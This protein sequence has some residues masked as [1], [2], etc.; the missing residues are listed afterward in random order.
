MIPRTLVPVKLNPASKEDGA[1]TKP[2]RLTTML[3]DR[4][5]VPSGTSDA[6]PLDGKSSIPA[7][8]PLQVLVGH[9][10]IP[11]GMEVKPLRDY[12]PPS[13][14]DA[15]LAIL[16]SRVVV[17]AYVEPVQPSKPGESRKFEKAPELTAELREVVEPDIYLTGEA[18]LLVEPEKK[19]DP[20]WDLVTRIVSVAVHFLLIIFLIS[21][22][23]IFPYH[24]PT[25]EE[26]VDASKLLGKV[27][28]P[29]GSIPKTPPPPVPTVHITPKV[30]NKIA[31]PRPEEHAPVLPPV[32]TPKPRE[33][34]D[35]PEAP[36]AHTPTTPTPPQQVAQ[37]QRPPDEPPVQQLFHQPTK[38]LKLG[39][40]SAD[41]SQVIQQGIQQGEQHAPGGSV[42]S[43]GGFPAGAGA[44]AGGPGMSSG[45]Q[46]LTPTEGV[47]F[48]SYLQRLLAV[49][50]RNWYAIMPE[51][52]LM[53][54][55]GVV[56]TTFQINRDGSVP[57]PDPVLERASGREPLDSAAMSAIRASSPFEPLPSQFKG[58]YIR[59]RIIFIYNIPPD[60]INLQ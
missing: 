20:K 44:N 46:I 49:L 11:R 60:Q 45:V 7:H 30:L 4:T 22:P 58:P 17:P 21:I 31:P 32:P 42:Y 54:D 9:T 1:P 3:D 48:N 16:D 29:P 41:P 33:N 38:P 8:F 56:F 5:V 59:L 6:P 52:A 28:I 40:P 35:L 51:S 25:Q 39:L 18:N 10:L 2:R 13:E 53:G 26:I 47:D 57:Y 24:P 23:K 50:K 27:Y 36:K 19:R 14:Y 12:A 43:G 37:E 34:A 15:P 55:K